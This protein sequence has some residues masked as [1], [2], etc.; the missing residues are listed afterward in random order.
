MSDSER[1]T[2]T[3][4]ALVALN[5]IV[6][7]IVAQLDN[8]Q[9]EMNT[10]A[11]SDAPHTPSKSSTNSPHCFAKPATPNDFTGNQNEGHTFLNSCD[12]Y[13]VLAPHQF[14]NDEAK[15]LWALLFMK[16]DRAALFV[17]HTLKLYRTTGTLPYSLWQ[18]FSTNFA[19][20]FCPKNETQMA[21]MTLETCGYFQGC[22]SVKE[23]VNDFRDLVQHTNYSEKPHIMLK[24]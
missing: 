16:S 18:E 14:S 4:V 11:H 3:E 17:D 1:I 6:A 24:F 21:Q 9:N 15:I 10:P 23:Y 7:H 8:V 19:T 20:E 22:R 12:L 5:N 13:F 2:Q